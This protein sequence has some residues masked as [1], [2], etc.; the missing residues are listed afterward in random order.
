M[1]LSVNIGIYIKEVCTYV[2]G[3]AGLGYWL[4]SGDVNGST[5]GLSHSE[6]H[7]LSKLRN[8]ESGF[9]EIYS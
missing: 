8:S 7:E 1:C 5:A 3:G 2:A 9:H 6:I 4:E